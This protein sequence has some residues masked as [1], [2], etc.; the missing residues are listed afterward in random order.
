MKPKIMLLSGKQGS[1]KT[2][3]MNEFMKVCEENGVTAINVIFADTIYKIHDFAM[4]L[5]KQRGV[6]RNIVKDGK[7]L[8]LL[9][10]EWGRTTLGEDIWVR[11]LMG[12]IENLSKKYQ[13]NPRTV[14]IVSDC[15]FKNEFDGVPGAFKVRLDASTEVRKARCSQW[16]ENDTHISETDLDG[17]A[18]EGKFDCYLDTE[19]FSIETCVSQLISQFEDWIQEQAGKL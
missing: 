7:L 19:N 12:E 9:G 5:L 4:D 10:T 1:G 15:R 6:E 11:C 16:R 2:T 18:L 8:Q 14:F 13:D 17:Y 3:T